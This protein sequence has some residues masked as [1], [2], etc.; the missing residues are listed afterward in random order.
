M[1]TEIRMT[2]RKRTMIFINIVITCIASS[3]LATALTT[4]L[5]AI[6]EDLSIDVSAGQ[7]L[8]SGY[9]LAM[10]IIMPLTAFLI[11]RFPTRRLYL[12]GIVLFIAGL[13]LCVV[14]PDFQ[15][16]MAARILQACGN[17]VLSS[18]AQVIIL[19]I[20][21]IEKRGTAMGWYGLSI[22]AAPVIAPTLAGVIVDMFG[23]RAI[24]YISIGIMVVSFC[25]ALGVLDNVLET[26][27]KKFDTASFV[28]SVFAFGGL[29]LGIG[30]IGNYSFFSLQV[31]L[32]LIIGVLASALFVYRQLHLEEPFLEL[33]ILKKKNYAVSVAG[34]M[35]LYFVM[36][37]SSILMPLYAQSVMG[38][39]ATVSGLIVLPGSA[40]M[41]IVSPFAGKI[42]DKLGMKILFVIG[43]VCMTVSCAGMCLLTMDTSVWM[44]AAWNTLR[45]TAIGCLMM[46]LVTWGT[47]GIGFKMISHGTALLTSLRT[48]AGAMGTAVFVGIMNTA[49]KNA[50]TK[51]GD[52]AGLH[53]ITTAFFWM[54]IVSALLVVTG[55]FLVGRRDD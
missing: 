45:T 2:D 54:T 4:A 52:A 15:I 49:S 48:V 19:T 31:L 33:R 30:N 41:A 17:G 36:M 32:V 6:I 18:M 28:L 5:P 11:T 25:W 14:A 51:Y 47:E 39:S 37:G 8:T 10:G 24:F 23:W 22:G 7:W 53:G 16:M 20:Y 9:S 34:S 1:E 43:A 29:T 13:V 27:K 42:Y 26:A 55:I 3:M 12:S 21:P 40:V 46:P 35:L 50:A 44:A 38:C